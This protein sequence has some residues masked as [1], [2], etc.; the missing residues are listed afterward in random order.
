MVVIL[1]VGGWVGGWWVGGWVGGRACIMC[2]CD[3]IF[4]DIVHPYVTTMIGISFVL[5]APG[6]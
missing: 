5:Y 3:H 4:G 1:W 6:L 2:A